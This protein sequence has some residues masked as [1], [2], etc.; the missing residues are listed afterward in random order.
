MN[1]LAYE[2]N[3]AAQG[4]RERA[5]VALIVP[6]VYCSFGYLSRSTALRSAC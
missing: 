3:E 6:V 2:R 1:S 4:T 5:A